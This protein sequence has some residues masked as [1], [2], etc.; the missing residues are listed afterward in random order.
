M[1]DDRIPAQAP[2]PQVARSP[3]WLPSLI[4]LVPLV[5]AIAG[6][7]LMVQEIRSKGPTITVA[8]STA[9]GI[10]AGKTKV[11]YKNVDIGN[12][13]GVHLSEDRNNAII[14]IELDDAAEDFAVADSR[15]WVVRPRLAGATVSGLGT[16]LSGAYIGVDGG[17]SDQRKEHFVGLENPPVVTSD[18]PGKRYVLHA[19]DIGSLDIG[20]PVYFRRI[21]VGHLERFEL[22][23]AGRR[24]TM[25]IFVRAPYDRFVTGETRFWHASGVDL[26]FGLEGLR[27]QTQS[28]ATILLGG[29]AFAPLTGAEHAPAASEGAAF[30]LAP[31]RDTAVK[32]PE[33]E[34]QV[35][36]MR[37]TDSVRGL[38]PGAPVDFRGIAIGSVQTVRLGHDNATDTYYAPVTAVIYPERLGEAGDLGEN[39]GQRAQALVKRGL[40]AQL[41]PGNIL[42]GQMYVALDFFPNAEPAD[43]AVLD[44]GT[45]R[46]PTVDAELVEIQ[47]QVRNILD[48]L[49]RVPFDEIGI[50]AR[51]TLTTLNGTL[52]RLDNVLVAGNDGMIPDL[53][54]S[55]QAIS[56]TL[57]GDSPTQQDT[58][59]A[60]RAMTDAARALKG[61]A[62]SLDRNPESLLRGRNTR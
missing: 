44:D 42:T 62:D 34:P 31:D 41:R 8:F 22:D 37:F 2:E 27:L 46:L 59:A 23:D 21:Q 33:G 40:R 51:N 43:F 10:V 28:L 60:L 61:L 14:T 7:S 30:F 5:A 53:R 45:V 49:E 50:E 35:V 55:L 6:V 47:T 18:E 12:V 24:I 4:W 57:S 29:I 3:R 32:R 19:D 52:K 25:E 58:R 54:D 48:K 16:L 39:P 20:S 13:T 36:H 15:F 1:S 56:Q 11:K 26:S 17:R 38:V 9:E